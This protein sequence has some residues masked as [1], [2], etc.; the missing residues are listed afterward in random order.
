[1]SLEEVT[2]QPP[3]TG[4]LPSFTFAWRYW[5]EYPYTILLLM[6]LMALHTIFQVMVPVLMGKLVDSLGNTETWRVPAWICAYLVGARALTY[7]CRQSAVFTWHNLATK[8]MAKMLTQAFEKVQNFSTEWHANNFAGSLVRKVTRGMWGFDQFG[9]T[10]YLVM[11]PNLLANIAVMFVIFQNGLEIGFFNF[12][13]SLVFLFI[14]IE[15]STEYV[16]PAFEESNQLDSQLGGVLSD[17]ITCNSL[18]KAFAIEEYETG[19]LTK[20]VDEWRIKARNAWWRTEKLFSLQTVLFILIE[21]GIISFSIWLWYTGNRTTGEV[22]TI[23]ASTQLAQTQIRDLGNDIRNLQHSIADMEDIVN[24]E[25]IDAEVKEVSNAV[26]LKVEKGLIAFENVTFGYK[27]QVLPIYENFSVTI[28]SSEKIA[29][30]GRSGSGKSTFVKLIQRLYDVQGGRITIDGYDIRKVSKQSLRRAFSIVPQEPILFHRS[31]AE[32][33]A[34][35][36]PDATRE[37]IEET[38]RKAYAHDF[39][40]HLPNSYETL[41]GERGIKL[42]GGERQRIGIA[43]SILANRSI[44]ILDEP[45]SNLD[46]VSEELIQKALTE[47]MVGRTTIIIAHRLSTIK[48][49]DRILV[50]D[51]GKIIEEGNHETLLSKPDSYYRFL[52]SLQSDGF[53]PDIC[54]GLQ[55]NRAGQIHHENQLVMENNRQG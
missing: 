4:F 27:N 14:T 47:L 45:T 38:A 3:R 33:I 17:A 13:S 31:L 11:Y 32:N 21:A 28:G 9:D 40:K 10:L 20:V 43:R 48:S 8:I 23:F 35:G 22:V 6:I 34:I 7:F 25:T 44:L 18:I 26:P 46:S 5:S 29:L 51:N 41:V 49:V 39:I 2:T 42:S 54:S 53:M 12:L 1:M 24:I 19:R 15:L 55:S 52:Y 16:A 36:N 50:F 37:E 30:V